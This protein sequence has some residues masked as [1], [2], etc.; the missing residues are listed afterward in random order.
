MLLASGAKQVL[1]LE[2]PQAALQG[3]AG[4]RTHPITISIILNNIRSEGS[5]V[6]LTMLVIDEKASAV[7]LRQYVAE[8][9]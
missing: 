2:W 8:F 4:V 3:L 7:W 9:S 6:G 1:L 5:N